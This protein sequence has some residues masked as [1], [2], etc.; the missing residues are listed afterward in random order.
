MAKL[1]QLLG[2]WWVLAVGATICA[3]L[4]LYILCGLLIN[5]LLP[6]RWW[7][8]GLAWI[9]F[10]GA[11]LWRLWK[12]RRAAAALKA[13]MIAAEDRESQAISEKMTAAL[14]RLKASG[15]GAL[16][17][18]P[19][20][21]IIGPPG[22]GKTTIIQKSGLR[23][24]NNEAAQGVG[25]TRNCDWWFTD[26]A[27]LIDTAGRYTSQDSDASRDA[28]G[29][30][31]FL[32][33]LKR[34]RPL[35][36]L[37]GIIVAIG[38]DELGT[39]PAEALDRH[40]VA[41]RARIAELSHELGMQLPVYVLF[42]KADLVAGFVEFF[43][44]LTVEGRRSVVGST[45][46]LQAERPTDAALASAYDDMVQAL[47]DRLPARLQA[48]NDPVRR[49]AALSLPARFIDLRARV[50]R[51]L[52][53]IFGLGAGQNA[54]PCRLRGFYITSGIQ[55]GTPFDRLLGEL[56][57]TLGRALRAR[58]SS[59]RAFFVNRLLKEVVIAEAGLA[60]PDSR[61]A[62]RERLAKVAATA[63]AG[64]F[65][66]ALLSAW[67]MSFASN[68]SGQND[69]VAVSQQ[70]AGMSKEID[71]GHVVSP[72]ASIAEVIPLLDGLR[73]QLP[74]GAEAQAEPPLGRRFGLYR[75]GLADASAA[76]YA[77][78][79]QRYLLPRLILTA[80]SALQQAGSDSVAAYEPLKVY[81]MLGNRAGSKRDDAFILRWLQDD[82]AAREF[83]GPENEALRARIALHTRAL[84]GDPGRFGRY[85]TGPLLDA[86]LVENA[87]ATI[88]AMTPAERALA[89]MRQQVVG[90]DWK[91]VG[92]ALL[93]GER[94]AFGNPEELAA[95]HIPFLFTKQGF[96]TGFIPK[97]ATIAQALDKD[98]WM[99]GSS[100]AAQAPL[101]MAE[102]GQRYAQEYTQRWM[103]MLALPAPAD[104]A[105]DTQGLA[106]LANQ[107]ASPLK[108]LAD[109]VVANT[110]GLM[111]DAKKAAESA[112]MRALAAQL[113]GHGARMSASGVAAA[114]IE[115][116]FQGL[117]DYAGGE[118]APLKQL[119][120]A[121]GKYQL[122]LAQ[123][124]VGGGGGGSGG[125]AASAIAAA[126]AELNVAAANAAAAAPGL[127]TFVSQVAGGSSR[128]AETTRTA[129]L[130]Q[131]YAQTVLPACQDVI[132]R[133]YP[134][135][136]GADLQPADVSRAAGA[137]SGFGRDQLGPYL[138]RDGKSWSWTGEPTVR[139]FGRASA[140]MFQRADE[141]QAMMGGNL[142]LRLSAAPANK[143]PIRLRSGGVPMD[144][145]PG[146]PAERFSWSPG[147]S[148]VSELLVEGESL[149]EEGPWSLF[150]MLA[151]AKK[152][153]LGQRRYRFVFSPGSALDIEVIGGP[154][155]FVVDGP[156]ALRC[157]AK[158]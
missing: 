71:P 112:G 37:N 91:L 80:E 84:L 36:P 64:L 88:A 136:S 9:T 122:A 147:G 121:L 51:F 154:D 126:A 108:K 62:R 98:R 69:M 68:A 12:Q 118:A 33:T 150:R 54:P 93:P 50:V 119:L 139:G 152:Q 60:I 11:A 31:A 133:G 67:G 44:D 6:A 132:G 2:N 120:G 75:Q 109:Q 107:G 18:L 145:A 48:E 16:Y 56:S 137:L 34:A 53:G 55:Q 116:H 113:A 46:P 5:A 106:R 14:D 25:G 85:L 15:K 24:I 72:S 97:A 81:L 140:R 49:G 135:G 45:L 156:F 35:Q 101:D 128:A 153:P 86:R 63:V 61:R 21:V 124:S 144:L 65:A 70:L 90:A 102:L 83:P 59:P 123:A 26:E 47:A 29:W 39:A 143:A 114:A 66:A 4:V 20:Y 141:V 77:D 40:V 23:L 78:G 105:R 28:K 95:A 43:D 155:P 32:R 17:Q 158:L 7:L 104:Y 8:I 103:D 13:A 58:S 87:Q 130:R 89:L 100:A 115:A 127:S 42:T 111:P 74:Y 131:S 117:R 134:F 148:Q 19:W 79:L 30:Q 142:V 149:R 3:T 157:P 110:T 125:G 52:D 82:L 96:Q 10:V 76:A 27:V 146:T 129:E 57:G 38:L 73:A 41:I 22:A 94:E 92:A 151:H 1:K 138:V 99:L